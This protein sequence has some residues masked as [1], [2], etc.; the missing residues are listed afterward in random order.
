[1]RKVHSSGQ[2]APVSLIYSLGF[3]PLAPR[4]FFFSPNTFCQLLLASR[5]SFHRVHDQPLCISQGVVFTLVYESGSTTTIICG[6]SSHRRLETGCGCLEG[7][8]LR[9]YFKAAKT[10]Q[11][12]AGTKSYGIIVSQAE[13]QGVFYTGKN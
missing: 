8:I 10:L 5:A 12:Q 1:M 13:T 4:S 6:Q 11:S 2:R 3:A 9:I 7:G